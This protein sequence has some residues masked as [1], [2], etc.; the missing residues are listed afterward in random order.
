MKIAVYG[1][2]LNEETFV[3]RFTASARD[4]PRQFLNN[5]IHA[6][7]GF[8]WVSPCHEY[9]AAD[10]I[11]ERAVTLKGMAIEQHPDPDKSRGQ[12]LPLL[13][14]AAREQPHSPRSAHY[15]GRE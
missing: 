3:R 11:E 13:E 1:I 5:R 12:Y 10:R 6:R 9:L 2:C 15:L 4:A 8:R 14:L 7:H